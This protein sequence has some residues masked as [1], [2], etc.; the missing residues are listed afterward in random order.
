M[1]IK[2]KITVFAVMTVF[3]LSVTACGSKDTAET[4][5][6]K[7]DVSAVES[8]TQ[9]SV[10]AAPE[11]TPVVEPEVSAN[12]E[13]VDSA[14]ASEI[15]EPEIIDISQQ[16][17]TATETRYG[18]GTSD[19]EMTFTQKDVGKT[20]NINVK[21]INSGFIPYNIDGYFLELDGKLE[22]DGVSRYRLGVSVPIWGPVSPLSGVSDSVYFDW[23]G[24]N[25]DKNSLQR[26]DTDDC[27]K[28]Y[29]VTNL[30]PSDLGFPGGKRY[31]LWIENKKDNSV[32]E[33]MAIA[34]GIY[35]DDAKLREIVDKVSVSLAE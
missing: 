22:D 27:Y 5:A 13:I 35:A 26:L 29:L 9:E 12:D 8:S 30:S 32:F 19:Y 16:N 20:L 10:Q 18:D 2:N 33:I 21:G 31:C 11:E 1:R 7:E 3:M 23:P 17:I 15:N 25:V 34:A 24:E 28:V 14:E 4:N 6:G